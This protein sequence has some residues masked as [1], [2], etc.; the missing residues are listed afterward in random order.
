M[1]IFRFIELIRSACSWT[2]WKKSFSTLHLTEILKNILER[3]KNVNT[4]HLLRY[5]E[6]ITDEI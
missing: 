3:L 2:F 6:F 5:W 4:K 1:A